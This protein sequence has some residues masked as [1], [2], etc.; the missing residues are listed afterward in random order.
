MNTPI[1][2]MLEKLTSELQGRFSMPGHKG[3]LQPFG[4][5]DIFTYDITELSG[6]DNLL[7]PEG[8]IRKS[9]E[10]TA[11]QLGAKATLYSVGG[12]TS[13]NLAMIRCGVGW[14][15][16]V[17]ASRDLHISAVNGLILA[18]ATPVFIETKPTVGS[19]RLADEEQ[20]IR[21]MQ[22]YPEAKA[23][24]VTY[25]NY[26]GQVFDL[27]KV[28][29]E[30]KKRNMALLVD[31]AHSAHFAY[32][33]KLPVSP[34]QGGADLCS[35]SL[36]KT[37][38]S[39]NQTAVLALGKESKFTAE[40]AK[41]Y[42]NQVQTT[43]PSYLLL[44]AMDYCQGYMEVAGRER[45]EKT[46][47]RAM[48]LEKRLENMPGITVYSDCLSKKDVLKLVIDVR[49]RG[50]TGFEAAELLE[51]QG[52][53]PETA[54]AHTVLFILTLMDEERD[55]LALEQAIAQLPRKRKTI[56][57]EPEIC[58]DLTYERELFTGQPK[59]KLQS[60]PL[61]KAQ[62][63]YVATS[64]GTYPPGIPVLLPGQK[65]EPR[66]VEMLLE[67]RRWG[68]SLFGVQNGCILVYNI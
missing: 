16:V 30:A 4:R 6:A 41:H 64:V 43:S 8:V 22:Q 59:R 68:Y 62:G 53:Y 11:K 3:K 51:R 63:H 50:M 60:V 31:G 55:Y 13:C 19:M 38:P 58:Y 33:D 18:G 7:Q 44:A 61:Q 9:Q 42:L 36:H 23:V 32:S 56:S 1:L 40:Q 46:V 26:Y 54:D 25:P 21:A 67:A 14:G 48:D 12:S 66:H 65:V 5:N 57:G 35:M 2:D 27:I 37:L 29:N 34:I 52:Y 45:L 49:G 47:Q 17:I 39:P 24:L 20:L 10:Y 15:D 28:A